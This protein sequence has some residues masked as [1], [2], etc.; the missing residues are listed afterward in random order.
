MPTHCLFLRATILLAVLESASALD[1]GLART[2]PMGWMTWERFRCT[3]DGSVDWPSCADDP[4]NCL[5]EELIKQHADILSQ[6]EWREAGYNYINIGSF[7]CISCGNLL[8]HRCAHHTSPSYTSVQ[9][10]VGRIT[11]AQPMASWWRIPR[12]FLQECAHLPIMCM[13][14]A[15]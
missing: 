9:M 12:A 4:A 14:K 1:N 7:A 3:A 11:T 8:L 10:I 2:P 15:G 5:N 13:P 6:P